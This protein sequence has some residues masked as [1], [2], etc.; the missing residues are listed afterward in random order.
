MR[1]F[2]IFLFFVFF[3]PALFAAVEERVFDFQKTSCSKDK[4][5]DKVFKLKGSKLILKF[6]ESKGAYREKIIFTN[7]K[8]KGKFSNREIKLKGKHGE[9]KGWYNFASGDIILLKFEAKKNSKYISLNNCSFVFKGNFEGL[10]L[11]KDLARQE[12]IINTLATRIAKK[13]INATGGDKTEINIWT[14]D[15]LMSLN[16]EEALEKTKERSKTQKQILNAGIAKFSTDNVETSKESQIEKEE[17][18]SK[19]ETSILSTSMDGEY[20]LIWRTVGKKYN[21]NHIYDIVVDIVRIKNGELEFVKLT[22]NYKIQQENRE[23]IIFKLKKDHFIVTGNLDLDTA[24]KTQPVYLKGSN[25][26]NKKGQYV[27]ETLYDIEDERYLQTVFQPIFNENEAAKICLYIAGSVK[28]CE[29]YITCSY[30]NNVYTCSREYEKVESQ[31]TYIDGIYSCNGKVID[32]FA[33]R[34]AEEEK[35]RKEKELAVKKKEEEEGKKLR[36]KKKKEEEEAKKRAQELAAKKKQEEELKQKLSTKI[37]QFLSI[38]GFYK[39]S[40]DGNFGQGSLQA[41]N[42]WRIANNLNKVLNID[43]VNEKELQL[44][45]NNTNEFIQNKKKEELAKKKEEEERKRKELVKS[46]KERQL[47]QL[48]INDLLAFVQSHP[49]EFDI[50]TLS[51]LMVSNKD[52][53]EGKWDNKLQNDF[54]LLKLYTQTIDSFVQ[55]LKEQEINRKEALLEKISSEDLKIKSFINNAKN[56]LQKNLTS[57]LS[58]EILKQIKMADEILNQSA[59]D[60]KK[61]FNKNIIKFI[62]ENDLSEIL[63]IETE[64]VSD[65]EDIYKV[66][67]RKVQKN[68]KDLGYYAGSIDG[69]FGEE[70]LRSLNQ[71]AKENNLEILVSIDGMNEKQFNFLEE[72]TIEFVKK[73]E[74]NNKLKLEKF[75]DQKRLAQIYINDLIAFNQNNSN[76]FDI[77]T[78]SE[79]MVSNKDILEGK[80]DNKLQQDFDLLKQYTL[81]SQLF[82][83]FHLLQNENRQNQLISKINEL[84]DNISNIIDYFKFYLQ[85]NMTSNLIPE[86]LQKIKNAEEGIS[87]QDIEG[88]QKYIADLIIFIE[89]K[90]LNED[91][92]SFLDSIKPQE[93][94]KADDS[95]ADEIVNNNKLLNVDFINNINGSD[96]I[97]LVNLSGKAPNAILNLGGEIV[98]ENDEAISC[99]YQSKEI[100]K[101]KRYYYYDKIPDRK[102]LINNIDIECKQNKLLNYDL[103]FFV[104]NDLLNENQEYVAELIKQIQSDNL[105]YFNVVTKEQYENDILERKNFAKQIKKDVMEGVRLGYGSVVINNENTTLCSDIKDNQETHKSIINLLQNEFNRLGYSKE[106]QNLSFKAKENT[107]FDV[108]REKCGFLYVDQDSL[109]QFIQ[110]FEKTKTEYEIMPIWYSPKQIDKERERLEQI[111]KNKLI[112]EQKRKEEEEKKHKLKQE[113]LKA[114]GTLKAKQEGELR[115]KNRN[116][117]ESHID[118]MEKELDKF[119]NPE[120]FT[121][122]LIYTHYKEFSK[123]MQNKFIEKWELDRFTI[124][125]FDYGKG[126]YRNRQIDTFSSILEFKLKN[127]K[128]GDYENYCIFLTI[129]DDKEFKSYREPLLTECDNKSPLKKYQKKHKFKS[130]WIIE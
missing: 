83:K 27:A 35:K 122:S 8:F 54:E 17:E 56:Y 72:Q 91:F 92:S 39:G 53:L 18:Y 37:Q 59:L 28:S 103:I 25:Q 43:E 47:A 3:S 50:I 19:S 34:K 1:Y 44:L 100:Q 120:I 4:N 66:D 58:P 13:I 77:I 24:R 76:E 93:I 57:P 123:F 88:K 2:L 60:E 20:M 104:K 49:N 116:V 29:R 70:S 36:E 26:T 124:V 84:N 33:Q 79:L 11:N 117:V 114:E 31:C 15:I 64:I 108:Q 78:L 7:N 45:E 105:R 127:N 23:K 51:E 6:D 87:I 118:F 82:E 101:N 42:E 81:K 48:Y 125:P 90:K 89:S 38:L 30:E 102:F 9:L 71:W 32:V 21:V 94:L 130:E 61:E 86:I 112:D 40:L 14:L 128:I 62:T 126:E 115:E 107:F 113:R 109:S 5:L 98:F 75:D 85:K 12:K 119:F 69:N 10:E 73:Q 46:N 67:V 96:L 99:F 68:L 41:L 22:R 65:K 110:G 74:E 106:I 121:N 16:F 52:I 80:W 95:K 97:V 111:N 63:E 129:M 55:F